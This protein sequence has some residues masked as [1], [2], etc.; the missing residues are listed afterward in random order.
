ME[1]KTM[2]GYEF[3]K[4]VERIFEMARKVCP[5]VTDE[6][7]DDNGAI[8]Y[9]NGNEGTPFDW[10]VNGRLC[11]FF[12]YHKNEAGFIKT[13]IH[14]DNTFLV[15]VYEDGGQKPTHEAIKGVLQTVEASSFAEVMNCIA[16]ARG[17]YNM[18]IN[19]LD[20][21]IDTEEFCK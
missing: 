6:M 9:M 5:D 14:K 3:K 8:Y 13:Y 12:I 21:D 16:D 15:Y 10:K 18:P 2:K 1:V 7:L 20:W 19:E 11:E 4:E 17:L